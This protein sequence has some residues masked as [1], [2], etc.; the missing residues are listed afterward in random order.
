MEL[1][2]KK[3]I[4]IIDRITQQTVSKEAKDLENTINQ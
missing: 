4:I 2:G 1:K 3:F